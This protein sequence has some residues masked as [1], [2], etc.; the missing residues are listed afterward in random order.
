M[1]KCPITGYVIQTQR[2][3]TIFALLILHKSYKIKKKHIIKL[4]LKNSVFL[5]VNRLHSHYEKLNMK[6]S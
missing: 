1:K 3:L 5:T 4:I 6:P 2:W